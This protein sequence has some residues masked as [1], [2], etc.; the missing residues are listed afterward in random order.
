MNDHSRIAILRPGVSR[1]TRIFIAVFLVF[2][3]AALV[4]SWRATPHS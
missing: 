4:V 3:I 1:W 2:S